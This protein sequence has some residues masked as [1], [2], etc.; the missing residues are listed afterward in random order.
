MIC[1]VAA[2]QRAEQFLSAQDLRGYVYQ[3]SHAKTTERRPEDWGVVFDV[4][5]PE[6]TLV[7]GP[8]VIIVNKLTGSVSFL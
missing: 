8:V 4:Y 3:F 2:R 5:S 7:E 6:K 1:E